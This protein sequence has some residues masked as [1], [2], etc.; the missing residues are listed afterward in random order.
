[1]KTSEIKR[2][3]KVG[4]SRSFLQ[5]IDDHTF[6]AHARGVVAEVTRYGGNLRVAR[7]LWAN[8][9]DN[10]YPTRANV[11]NLAKVGSRQF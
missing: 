6:L 4:Y 7:V 1:M 10:E 5:A 3:D 2:G 9:P 8:D 11:K